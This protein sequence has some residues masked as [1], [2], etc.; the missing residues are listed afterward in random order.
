MV[1]C[2]FVCSFFYLSK[3]VLGYLLL[4]L[5]IASNLQIIDA[6]AF[7]NLDVDY[8]DSWP[9]LIR[10]KASDWPTAN[11]TKDQWKDK[12]GDELVTVKKMQDGQMSGKFM[13]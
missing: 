10:G 3:A 13:K 1:V 6:S 5:C 7:T 2:L 11:W 12:F 8:D 9:L 4:S